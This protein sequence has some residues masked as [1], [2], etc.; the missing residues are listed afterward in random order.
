[1]TLTT[2]LTAVFWLS[3]AGTLF[4]GY[5]AAHRLI[6]KECAFNESCPYVFGIPACDIGF[7]LFLSLLGISAKAM[8]DIFAVAT[9][10]EWLFW[11][12]LVGTVYAGVLS[13]RE[14]FGEVRAKSALIL[15]TCVYG[16]VVFAAI[17][18]VTWI[19]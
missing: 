10:L 1:M 13:A 12:A 4:A 15:P 7:V 2:A 19:A 8:F 11:V 16:F 14:L 17:F 9:A 6:T 3:I 18:A 5:L